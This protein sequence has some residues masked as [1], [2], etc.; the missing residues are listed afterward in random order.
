MLLVY[1]V[2]FVLKINAEVSKLGVNVL[3]GFI[4]M[5]RD[6]NLKLLQ[7]HPDNKVTR[8]LFCSDVLFFSWKDYFLFERM[9]LS[10]SFIY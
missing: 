10:F 8:Q 1:F 7:H 5:K 2:D 9:I 3:N 6:I 4:D